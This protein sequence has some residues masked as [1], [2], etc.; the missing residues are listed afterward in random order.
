MRLRAVALGI[1]L[2]CAEFT[3]SSAAVRISGDRGG[4]IGTYI[5]AFAM[6]RNTGEMVVIDGPCLSA[7]T[8]ILGILPRDQVC[9][10]RRARLGFHAAWRPDQHG[11]PASSAMGTQVLM[12]VY[13]PKVRTWIRRKG[14]LKRKMIFLQ[15][16][17]LA[18]FFPPCRAAR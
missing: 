16:R 14:G 17:E 13:P 2:L 5:E 8:L 18:S 10:T 4:R 1:L 12:E 6:L 7:C 11:R 15:G 3:A 9:V